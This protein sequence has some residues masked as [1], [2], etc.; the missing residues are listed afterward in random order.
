MVAEWELGSFRILVGAP[1]RHERRGAVDWVRFDFFGVGEG[2]H[3]G[4]LGSFRFFCGWRGVGHA[5]LGSFRISWLLAL[6]CWLLGVGF[7]ELGSF[8]IFWL[9]GW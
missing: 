6:G 9:L 2:G 5:K 4:R 1:G 8:R 7:V 3:G